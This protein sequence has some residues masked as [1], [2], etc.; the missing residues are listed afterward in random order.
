MTI[1]GDPIVYWKQSLLPVQKFV[2]TSKFRIVNLLL[3]TFRAE[4]SSDN[5]SAASIAR[6]TKIVNLHDWTMIRRRCYWS[7]GKFNSFAWN[8]PYEIVNYSE[9]VEEVLTWRLTVKKK[10]RSTTISISTIT[11]KNTAR[12]WSLFSLSSNFLFL[13]YFF[14]C[15]VVYCSTVLTFP[16]CLTKDWSTIKDEHWIEM[17]LKLV[18]LWIGF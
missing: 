16:V 7:P 14:A 13:I 15:D 18:F 4:R 6:P 9:T 11:K 2:V 3:S 12:R 17:K 1:Y 8:A 10:K 5:P